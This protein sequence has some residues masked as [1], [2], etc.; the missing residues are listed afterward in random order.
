MSDT[1]RSRAREVRRAARDHLAQLRH[2]RLSRRAGSAPAPHQGT[3]E[4]TTGQESESVMF[5]SAAAA[6]ALVDASP[7]GSSDAR[8]GTESGSPEPLALPAQ[9]AVPE[10]SAND[11]PQP[12]DEA[13]P[14][15]ASDVSRSPESE[16]HPGASGPEEYQDD[17]QT[18][19]G[20]AVNEIPESLA[21][22]TPYEAAAS[23]DLTE[24]PG[25]GP[26]LIWMLEQCGVRSLAELAQAEPD[27]LTAQMGLV[28]EMLDLAGWV[29][30]AADVTCARTD[31]PQ[32][33]P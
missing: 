4:E 21:D 11:A 20:G 5:V 18:R 14:E 28:G 31:G 19:C 8:G 12:G 33:D 1:Q 15:T 22:Q 9:P 26:G 25:A 23:S 6:S 30:F 13:P 16:E 27:G 24:L 32:R 17:L 2:E 10:S 3:Q 7:S 29:A